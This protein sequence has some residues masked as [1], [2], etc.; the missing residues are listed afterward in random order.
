MHSF[1]AISVEKNRKI[2]R[3]LVSRI[4]EDGFHEQY[5]GYKGQN[6][7]LTQGAFAKVFL[8]TRNETKIKYFVKA[9]SKKSF[10]NKQKYPHGNGQ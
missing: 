4:F 7:E 1:S 2:Y 8:V 5:K 10:Q 3:I 9:F 6:G